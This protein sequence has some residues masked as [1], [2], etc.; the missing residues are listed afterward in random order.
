[1][2]D[3]SLYLLKEYAISR[4]AAAA[5]AATTA[6]TSA[7]AAVAALPRS[8]QPPPRRRCRRA[9]L[10]Q[11]VESFCCLLQ[12]KPTDTTRVYFAGAELNYSVSAQ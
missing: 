5:A 1:M 3:S 6:A 10:P 9:L 4:A 8:S 11:L 7:A 12:F 2:W